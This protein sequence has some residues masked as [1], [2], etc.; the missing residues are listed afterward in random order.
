MKCKLNRYE[1]IN[2]NLLYNKIRKNHNLVISST[3]I[4]EIRFDSR[5]YPKYPVYNYVVI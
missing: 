1:R 3:L 5:K 2:A 4:L